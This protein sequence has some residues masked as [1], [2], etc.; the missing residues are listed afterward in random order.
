MAEAPLSLNVEYFPDPTKGRPIFNGS[1]YVG[2]PDLDPITEANRV[3]VVVIQ[4][5]GTRVTIDKSAQPLTTGAGGQI[6]YLGENVVVLVDGSYSV[7]VNDSLGAQMYYI[8]RANEVIQTAREEGVLVLNGSFETE[9]VTGIADNW[10]QTPTATGTVLPDDTSAAHGF[11]SLKFTS[12]DATGAGIATS[13]RFNVSETQDL[14]VRFI[15]KSSNVATLNKVE[16]K[17][18]NLAGAPIS[19]VTAHSD[20]TTNPT[21][22]TGYMKR[23]TPP[24]GAVEGEVILTGVDALGTV[25]LGNTSF[26]GILIEVS[27]PVINSVNVD[28]A[29][30]RLKVSDA[31]TGSPVLIESEGTDANV[32][33]SSSLSSSGA[34]LPQE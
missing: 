23:V 10:T 30:N 13:D 4:E 17:F 33:I 32:S 27:N 1:V 18:Y 31:I 9:T 5:S 26:D 28:S 20:G 2:I 34:P 8:P 15:Y 29:V 3:D 12:V 19:T 21:A 11:K 16:V 24:A 22:Y 6:Q 14:D 25:T 7:R